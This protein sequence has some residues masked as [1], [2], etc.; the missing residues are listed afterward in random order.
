MKF[1]TKI[2][3]LFRKNKVTSDVKIPIEI[4]KRKR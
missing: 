2:L 3:K 1:I 4:Y